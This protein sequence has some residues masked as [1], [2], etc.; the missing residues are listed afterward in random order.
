[1]NIDLDIPNYDGN[2]LDVI[3]GKTHI[4][5]FTHMKIMSY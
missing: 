2:A 1:M 4:I 3:W 5:Q